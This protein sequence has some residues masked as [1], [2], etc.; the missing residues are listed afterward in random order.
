VGLG[1]LEASLKLSVLLLLVMVLVTSV[2]MSGQNSKSRRLR[3]PA[4]PAKV[5]GPGVKTPS[6]LQY[7]DIEKGTGPEAVKASKVTVNYTGWL[8]NGK[9]VDSSLNRPF[10]FSLGRGQVLRGWDEGVAGMRVGGKR[11][12][13]IPPELGLGAHSARGAGSIPPNATLIF[14]VELLAVR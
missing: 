3:A 8:I 1:I 7:W 12:L 9:M 13:R 5:D 11:Q 6:G 2:S 4:A 14:D 10:Q